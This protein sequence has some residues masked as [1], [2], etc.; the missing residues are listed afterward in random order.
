MTGLSWVLLTGGFVRGH[1][2]SRVAER[3]PRETTPSC[4]RHKVSLH[5]TVFTELAPD[6]SRAQGEGLRM[7]LLWGK[8]DWG[9][10]R[11]I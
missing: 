4:A 5:P 10:W 9:V 3:V 7:H 6:P 11:H 8:K 2:G 1:R